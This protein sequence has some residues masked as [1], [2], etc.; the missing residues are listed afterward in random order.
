MMLKIY[1]TTLRDGSQKE[2]ISYSTEDKVR[3]TK[4][5]DQLGVDYV[6]G[7]WP[8]SNPKDIEYFLRVKDMAFKNLKVEAFGSTRRANIEAADDHNLNQIIKSK[9]KVAT[10]F[11]KTWD[12]HVRVALKTTLEENLKMIESSI[13]YLKSHGLEVNF[14]AEHFFDGYKANPAYAKEVIKAAQR[15][16][17]DAIVFCD[18]NGGT[19]P[20]SVKKIIDDVKGLITC[21][22]GIHAHND[23]ELAVANSLVAFETGVNHIQGTINGFGERCGNANLSSLIPNLLLKYNDSLLPRIKL[24]KMTETSRFVSEIINTSHT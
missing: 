9:V 17:A 5:L 11:G 13:A 2:G 7:G 19:L 23:A 20:R 4:A 18:T 8:G 24:R 14:D 16:G 6:E 22:M 10:I 12:L 21:E 15:G 1:D 3:I